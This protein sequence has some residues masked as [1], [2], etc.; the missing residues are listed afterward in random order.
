[1]PRQFGY[2]G[3]SY[4]TESGFSGTVEAIYSG[5]LYANNANTANVSSYTIANLRLG[6]DFQNGNWMIRPYIG[7]NNL[8]DEAY[9]SNIRI[10]AFGGRYFEPAPTRNVYAGVVVNFQKDTGR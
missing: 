1:L 8:F 2:L 4:N 10:N 5:D 7:I 6:Y 9:N 3:L